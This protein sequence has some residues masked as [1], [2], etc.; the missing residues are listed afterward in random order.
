MG[1]IIQELHSIRR[2]HC[3][4]KLQMPTI[5]HYCL[6]DLG[7]LRIGKLLMI[8]EYKYYNRLYCLLHNSLVMNMQ[9]GEFRRKNLAY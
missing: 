2:R 3:A 4:I 5:L 8:D 1:S 7:Y 9:K 6:M